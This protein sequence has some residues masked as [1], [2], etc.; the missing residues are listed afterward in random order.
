MGLTEK[1]IRLL[2][3]QSFRGGKQKYTEAEIRDM[4]GAP[5]IDE[6]DICG[7]GEK[8]EECPEAYSHMTMGY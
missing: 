8:L 4:V 6:D 2:A 7:C 5:S 3:E 1:Q